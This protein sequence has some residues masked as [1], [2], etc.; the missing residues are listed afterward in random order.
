MMKMTCGVSVYPVYDSEQDVE[1]CKKY[2]KRAAELGYNEVFSSLHLPENNASDSLPRV[3]EFSRFV[4]G[5][6]ME[7]SLDISGREFARILGTDNGVELLKQVRADWIRLDY[8]F[9]D[10]AVALVVKTA[11]PGGIM[12]NASVLDAQRADSMVRLCTELKV[13]LRAHHNFYPRPETGLSMDFMCEKSKIFVDRGV[14]VTACVASLTQP[15]APIKCGLPTVESQREMP[16]PSA[17]AQ[18]R[19][20]CLISS[21]LI[22]DPFADEGELSGVAAVCQAKPVVLRV[23]L[24]SGASDEEKRI[25]FGGVHHSRPDR[26]E[27]SIRSQSSREMASFAVEIEPRFSAERK[28]YDITVDNLNYLRYSGEMQIVTHDLPAD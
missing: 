21:I 26:A 28:K 23:R 12:C 20:T 2:V 19:A 5:C 9:D 3:V 15:R 6:G 27:F 18:L 7:L 8:G 22:G 13:G 17:A 16:C 24:S 11:A 10:A 14:P 1:R 25:L 4:H